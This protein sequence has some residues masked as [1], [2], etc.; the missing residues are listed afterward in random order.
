MDSPLLYIALIA[1]VVVFA[2]LLPGWI[3]RTSR[4][5]AARESRRLSEPRTAA[6]LDVLGT[7]LVV[8]APESVVRE[9][10]DTVALQRPRAFTVRTDGGYGIRFIEPD[11][12]VVRLAAASDGTR[13]QVSEFREY[14]GMPNTWA[15]WTELCTHVR[16]LAADRGIATTDGPRLRFDRGPGSDRT[17]TVAGDA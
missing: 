5:A 8:H 7:T 14:L 16:T 9:L 4:A 15:F 12:A 6:A 3:R 13:L 10:V 11:D 1:V 2:M 17:W